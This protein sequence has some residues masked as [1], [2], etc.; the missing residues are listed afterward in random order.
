[1]VTIEDRGSEGAA[2]LSCVILSHL[3]FLTHLSWVMMLP[4]E[5]QEK[6]YFL[7]RFYYKHSSIEKI[8]R[9]IIK[10][11]IQFE[12]FFWNPSTKII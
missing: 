12:S 9:V 10:D 4:Q 7:K 3:M 11:I 5:I 1:M 6:L 8:I 2:L